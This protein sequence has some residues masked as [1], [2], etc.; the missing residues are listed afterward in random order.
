MLPQTQI[1]PAIPNTY[2]IGDALAY[3]QSFP[4]GAIAGIATSPPY[5]KAF[6]HRGG[7][8]SN[9]PNSKLM[10]NNYAGY[11]D[12]MPPDE[13]IHWQ[14]AFLTESLR[15][16][17]PDGVILYNIGRQIANLGENRRQE[18][19]T[20]FP[21]R[22][23]II[24]N[25]G[26]SNNQGG[27]VPTIFPPI[28]EFVYIIAGRQWRLPQKW[29]PEMRKWGDVWNINFE[30]GNPHPAPFPVKLAE[31]MV[32]TIDGPVLDPFAGSGTI[33]IAAAQLGYP[34]YLNDISPAYQA[35]FQERLN[36]INN[37]CDSRNYGNR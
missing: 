7:H 4:D 15:L 26:S 36:G 18:I 21:V 20:D 9:W 24:W 14:R 13:Y 6:R 10:A 31:R 23:T 33:G 22:Q 8:K 37:P 12:D 1:R 29:L 19:I 30:T 11:D 5:N 25:R 17:G 32:K 35:I 34:Y 3:M 27:K 16:V 28:Y 2:H